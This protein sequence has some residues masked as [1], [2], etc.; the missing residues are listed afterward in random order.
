LATGRPQRAD[1]E[2]LLTLVHDL[3]TPL[4]V[5]TGFADLLIAKGDELPP[6]QRREYLDRVA[7]A[8]STMRTLL[9][10]VRPERHEKPP[11]GG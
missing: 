2:R 9:D 3:R 5:I 1:D 8:A 4:V 7:V 6:A 11:A 10:D